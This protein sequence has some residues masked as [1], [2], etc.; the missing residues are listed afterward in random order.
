M[1]ILLF[2]NDTKKLVINENSTDIFN[3]GIVNILLGC[4]LQAG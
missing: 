1:S 4:V 2:F 3:R